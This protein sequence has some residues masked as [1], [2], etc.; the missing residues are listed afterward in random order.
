MKIFLLVLILTLHRLAAVV[1]NASRGAL[2]LFQPLLYSHDAEPFIEG[3]FHDLE[4]P[5]QDFLKNPDC[6]VALSPI[7][8]VRD[9][10]L[11]VS[12]SQNKPQATCGICYVEH[13][14]MV[15]KL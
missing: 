11:V 12:L 10:L 13:G 1:E 15:W 14:S 9:I 2:A 5:T 7:F 6:E 8:L 3:G 4:K